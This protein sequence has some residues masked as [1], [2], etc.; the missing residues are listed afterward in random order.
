[1]HGRHLF[2]EYDMNI[3][4][5]LRPEIAGLILGEPGVQATSR[6]VSGM[7]DDLDRELNQLGASLRPMHP[8]VQDANLGRFFYLCGVPDAE[9]PQALQGLRNLSAITAAYSKEPAQPA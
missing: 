9:V 3:V 6:E 1:M 2:P 5:Q 7:K 4:I 8:G